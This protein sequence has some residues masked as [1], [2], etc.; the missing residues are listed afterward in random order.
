DRFQACGRAG[1]FCLVG[2]TGQRLQHF[3]T[4]AARRANVS[5]LTDVADVPPLLQAADLFFFPSLNEGFG[6]AVAEAAA[7]GLPVVATDLPTIREACPENMHDFLIAPNDDDQAFAHI[8][9]LLEAPELAQ[10]LAP[11]ARQFA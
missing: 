11:R 4:E 2:S 1:H 8:T 10:Q 5:V 3:K 9:S 7:A 6:I